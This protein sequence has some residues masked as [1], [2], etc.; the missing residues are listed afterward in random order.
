MMGNSLVTN[1]NNIHPVIQV[2]IH[3]D[4]QTVFQKNTFSYSGLLKMCKSIKA[5]R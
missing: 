3:T 1:A 4:K 2:H 5:L